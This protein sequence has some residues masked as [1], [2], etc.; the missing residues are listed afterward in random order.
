MPIPDTTAVE[1]TAGA[2]R[3]VPLWPKSAVRIGFGLVWAIDAFF[4]WR[5]GFING[6]KGM[7]QMAGQGQPGWLHW[8]FSATNSIFTSDPH[9]WAYGIAA[10]ETLIAV[11]LIAGF[12]RKTTY[13]VTIVSGLGIWAVAEG[14]GGPYTASSTDIGAAC[15]YALVALALLVLSLQAGPSRYSADY[16]LEQRIPWWHTVAEFGARNHPA[17]N[18]QPTKPPARPVT[19]ATAAH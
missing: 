16:Y 5:P 11:A 15:I 18:A 4:K 14:F 2:A 12:A 7:V 9:A 10:L 6:F 8:F 13:L 19:P 1:T 3:P 17:P